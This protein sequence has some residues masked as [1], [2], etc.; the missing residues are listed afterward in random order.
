[1]INCL[2]RISICHVLEDGTAYDPFRCIGNTFSYNEILP[3]TIIQALFFFFSFTVGTHHEVAAKC[4]TQF[5]ISM[6][7][8]YKSK[9]IN[10]LQIKAYPLY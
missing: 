5:K 3:P 7:D 4:N 1:M 6:F 9:K 10:H 8:L 2:H